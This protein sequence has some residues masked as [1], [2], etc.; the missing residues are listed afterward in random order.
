MDEICD[1]IL[2]PRNNRQVSTA[3]E[4]QAAGVLAADLFVSLWE[5]KNDNS[6]HHSSLKL[7][8]HMHH[9]KLFL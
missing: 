9:H 4:L 7:M 5:E 1:I 6:W 8:Q 2:L 3:I